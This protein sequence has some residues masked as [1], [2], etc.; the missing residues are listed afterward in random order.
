MHMKVAR[1]RA[2]VS[3]ANFLSAFRRPPSWNIYQKELHAISW[4]VSLVKKDSRSMNYQRSFLN[5]WIRQRS[6]LKKKSY[7]FRKVVSISAYNIFELIFWIRIHSGKVEFHFYV[8][9]PFMKNRISF[10]KSV[11]LCSVTVGASP[12]IPEPYLQ[13]FHLWP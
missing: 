10:W 1:T 11:K 4:P 2:L 7:L 13:F 12:W 6:F 9:H 3:W 5:L 8:L